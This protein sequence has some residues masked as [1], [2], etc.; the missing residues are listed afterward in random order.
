MHE[1]FVWK[2]MEGKQGERLLYQ[3]I[4]ARGEKDGLVATEEG[5]SNEGSKYRQ[6]TRHTN[7]H[8]DIFCRC[9]NRLM[10]FVCEVCNEVPHH[11]KES[12]SLSHLDN[13]NQKIK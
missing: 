13:C 10:E 3:K 4:N 9:R 5:I 6:D 7:P 8:V 2:K 1:G 12:K 11:A